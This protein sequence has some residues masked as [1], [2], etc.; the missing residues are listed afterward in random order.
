M[1]VVKNCETTDYVQT[2]V[3]SYV[4]RLHTLI[5]VNYVLM[6]LTCFLICVNG[7]PLFF[8]KTGEGIQNLPFCNRFLHPTFFWHV[9][10]FLQ[11]FHPAPL[12]S[13]RDRVT[14]QQ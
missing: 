9:R 4:R 7:F 13:F 3:Y 1:Y 10:L 8:L 2:Y 14:V 12:Y 6:Y 11:E 5:P